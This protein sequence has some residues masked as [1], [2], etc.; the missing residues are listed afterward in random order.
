M[1]KQTATTI[2]EEVEEG[3]KTRR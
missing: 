2:L 1:G 3:D